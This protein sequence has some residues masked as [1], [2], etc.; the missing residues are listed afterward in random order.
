MEYCKCIKTNK[1]G[2]CDFYGEYDYE[3]YNN[4][5][6][7]YYIDSDLYIVS[8]ND[9]EWGRYSFTKEQFGKYF[10]LVKPKVIEQS[11]VEA[12]VINVNKIEARVPKMFLDRS[13]HVIVQRGFNFKVV[14]NRTNKSFKELVNSENFTFVDYNFVKRY[15]P[16]KATYNEHKLALSEMDFNDSKNFVIQWDDFMPYSREVD[17]T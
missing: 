5:K 1:H 7:S 2:R 3:F 17:K 14:K 9:T 8:V 11:M 16:N 15:D 6:Y 13:N 12:K 4:S 10:E